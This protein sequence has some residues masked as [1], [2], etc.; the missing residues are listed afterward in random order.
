MQVGVAITLAQPL[1]VERDSRVADAVLMD[2][3]KKLALLEAGSRAE[4][5]AEAKAKRDQAAAFLEEG[6][7]EFD[8]C[9]VR[10]PAPGT[11]KVLVTLGQYVSTFAPTTLVRLK[12][13]VK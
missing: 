3:R 5:V 1:V 12:P 7:A 10:V 13:D 9:T 8:Q 11:V 6:K 2:A 4:D